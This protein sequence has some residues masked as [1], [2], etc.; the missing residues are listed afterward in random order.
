MKKRWK[1]SGRDQGRR[2]VKPTY[3][4]EAPPP[5]KPKEAKREPVKPLIATAGSLAEKDL[6]LAKAPPPGKPGWLKPAVGSNSFSPDWATT[7][8]HLSKPSNAHE[9][10]M[11]KM[12][13]LPGRVLSQ[14]LMALKLL[15]AR[16]VAHGQS[17]HYRCDGPLIPGQSG[18]SG[19]HSGAT[20]I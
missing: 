12:P 2:I 11:P 4:T 3:P 8:L 9:K 14:M 1:N 17:R 13:A 20:L 18:I 15:S 6:V 5:R 19:R 10:L 16:K 7:S